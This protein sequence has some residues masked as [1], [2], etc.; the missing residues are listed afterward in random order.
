M[1]GRVQLVNYS[2]KLF[3][4][5]IYQKEKK[6]QRNIKK[7][8]S[9]LKLKMK[10]AF[11]ITCYKDIKALN[12]LVNDIKKIKKAK[13]FIN[14]DKQQKNFVNQLKLL[15]KKNN[16]HINYDK[17]NWGSVK[18]YN[19]FIKILN[20]AIRQDCSYFHWIDGRT[21]II[22]KPKYFSI[23]F[24]KNNKKTFIPYFKLPYWRINS[25]VIKKIVHNIL[26]NGGINRVKYFHI[27]DY[28]KMQNNSKLFIIL[29]CLFILIQKLF[30]INRLSFKKYYGGVGYFSFS[31][32]AANYLTKNYKKIKKK[33]HN[34]LLAEEIISQ[35]IFLN[36]HKS[37]KRNIINK[38]LIYQN[39]IKKNGEVPAILDNKDLIKIKNKKKYIFARKFDS[40]FSETEDL[41]KK[42]IS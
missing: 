39:W 12:N 16:L 19:A 5:N 20:V 23:F 10:H 29:N 2:K 6:S 30:F 35:T 3:S 8:K 41:H 28:I 34:T 26:I 40:R 22:V 21:R 36:S 27:V 7:Y 25:S 17:R 11:L 13:I 38:T 32:E 37:L 31:L 1:S 42:L 33:F 24:K 14:A 9:Y 4:Y 15:K 18:H